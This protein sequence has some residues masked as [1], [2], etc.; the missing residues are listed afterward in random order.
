MELMDK[1]QGL[2]QGSLSVEEYRQQMEL[3]L[4]R[5]GLREEERTSIARFL[6][7]LNMEV[8]DKVELLPYRDLDDLVQFCIMKDEGQGILRVAPSKLKDEKGKTIERQTPKASMQEK[9]SSIKCFKCLGRG[10]IASQ[11]PTKKTM[12]MKGQDIYSSQ[13][14]ATT[15]PSSSKSEDAKREESSEEMYPQEEGDLLMVRRLLRGQSYDLTQSQRENIFH[16]RCKIF[17]STCSLI[18]DS[19]SCCNCCSTRLVSKLSLAITPHSKPYK[20]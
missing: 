13:D 9:T 3:L 14:E 7:G 2:R 16:T 12:I 15:S 1:L 18:I 11:C 19:G 8:R 20:L 6:C 5:A 17:Y 10:H 4:L